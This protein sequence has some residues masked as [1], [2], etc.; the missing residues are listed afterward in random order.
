MGQSR[1][2]TTGIACIAAGIGLVW[3]ACTFSTST[4]RPASAP[5]PPRP[6]PPPPAPITLP[7]PAPAP[8]SAPAPVPSGWVNYGAL[9]VP[10][11]PGLTLPAPSAT[12]ATAGSAAAT[13]PGWVSV[14]GIPVPAIPGIT[15]PAAG[16]PGAASLPAPAAAALRGGCGRVEIGGRR[17]PLD[18]VTATY[19]EIPWASSLAIGRRTLSLRDGYVGASELPKTVDHRADNSEGPIRDQ[20]EVGACT[21]FSF[22]AAVDHAYARSSGTGGPLSVM[23]VWSRYHEPVMQ[24]A[25]SNNLNKGLTF[26]QSWAYDEKTA[27]AW[28]CD[29]DYRALLRVSSCSNPDPA[30]VRQA[31]SAAGVTITGATRIGADDIKEALAKGQD[32]WFGMYIDGSQFSRV[33]GSPAVVPNG[34][35]RITGSGHAMLL[36]GYNTQSDGTYYLIHNSW[37]TDWGDRGYAWI[38]EDTLKRNI[39][40]AY[41]V[42]VG[43]PGKASAGP[44]TPATAAP[45]APAVPDVPPAPPAGAC[46]EGQQPDTL[47]TMCLPACPDGSPRTLNMCPPPPSASSGCPQGYTNLLGICVI[48]A[49][50]L[51]GSDAATGIRYRCGPGG[52]NYLYPRGQGKCPFA[53]CSKSCPAPKFHLTFGP[54]GVGCSD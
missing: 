18:C 12:T 48:A 51:A 17:I 8:P 16:A 39:K 6:L 20:G 32:V 1:M 50:A 4:S 13:P 9:V 42:E 34:D 26:E 10:A 21:A 7:A 31:D 30:R 41:L 46:P 28:M 5:P 45:T 29:D 15:V 33:R 11:I 52:C 47:L 37:G 38:R 25:A 2:K 35:F 54:L 53:T 3:A 22:A 24:Y 36:A 49:P 43:K 27:C 19:A 14:A 40:S 23:H 44:A